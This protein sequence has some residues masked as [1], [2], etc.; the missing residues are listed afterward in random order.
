MC[1][2]NEFGVYEG[3]NQLKYWRRRRSRHVLT[4]SLLSHQIELVKIFQRP[5]IQPLFAPS[6]L[7]LDQ[8]HPCPQDPK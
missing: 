5:V 6:L 2:S 3:L 7:M 1:Q 8:T 4:V